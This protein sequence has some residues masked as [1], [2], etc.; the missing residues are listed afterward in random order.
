MG[1]KSLDIGNLQSVLDRAVGKCPEASIQVGNVDM[2]CLLDTGAQI[3]TIT[4]EFYRKNLENGQV[5]VDVSSFIRITAANGLNV[6]YLGYIERTLTICGIDFPNCGFLIVKDPYGTP[7]EERKVNVPGVI[8]SNILQTVQKQ[9][10][11]EWGDDHLV[12]LG[13]RPQG[14]PWQTVLALY[15]EQQATLKRSTGFVRTGKLPVIVPARV[16]KQIQGT[17][18]P[19]SPGN[20]YEAVVDRS[21]YLASH[22]PNGL[23]IGRSLVTVDQSG[24]VPVQVCNFGDQDLILAPKTRLASITA[25]FVEG[26]TVQVVDVTSDEVF[27][28]EEQSVGDEVPYVKSLLGRMDLGEVTA[29]QQHVLTDL[30]EKHLSVFSKSDDDIGCVT[31]VEHEIHTKDDIPV[32]VPHRRVP[33][34]QWAEVREYLRKTVDRGIIR[35]SSSPYASP[36][37][38]VR[39]NTGDIRLCVDYR[40][41]NAKTHKDAYPLPRIEEALESLKGA[42]HFCSLDLA[43]GYYQIPM[44]E[45]DI[46][47][48]AFRVGTG[49]LYEFTRMPFGVCNGPATFM[50]MMDKIFGDENF[51]SLLIYL[52]DILI[53]ASSFEQMIERLDMVL[54]RL[55]SNNL[56]VKPEKCH[57]MKRQIRFLGH[58]VSQEGIA[59]DPEKTR[60]VDEWEVPKS[61]SDLR[62]FLGLA[63]YYR[64][65]VPHFSQIARPLHEL[66]ADAKPKGS[67][68]VSKPK[69]KEEFAKRWTKECEEAFSNLK[70]RL[71]SA[72]VLG[73]PD[74]TRPFKLET[75]ASLRGL[76]AVLSQ[77]QDGRTVV[78]CYASR[79]LHGS[80]LNMNNYS[81]MKLELLAL[82]WAITKKF[83]DLL[84]GGKFEVYTDNNPLSYIQSTVKVGATEMRW[85]AELAVFDFTVKYRS[86]RSNRNADALSR[87]EQH[88]VEPTT[89]FEEVYTSTDLAREVRVGGE[90]MGG[91]T[92]VPCAGTRVPEELKRAILDNTSD[93]WLN[94]IQTRSTRTYTIPCTAMPSLHSTDLKQMQKQDP[95]I[96]RLWYYWE[97]GS[98]P[99]MTQVL[100]EQKPVRKLLRKWNQ[101][102][103]KEG[104]LYRSVQFEGSCVKQLLLPEVMVQSFLKAVH[105]DTA[106]P[107]A[108]K[109]LALASKRCYW[110]S[111]TLDID[112]YCRQCQRCTL[113]KAGRKL[114]STMGNLIAKKPMEILAVDFTILE[115]ACGKENVLVLTDV[116][117]KFTQAVA[118]RDQLAKTVAQCLVKEWFVRYGVPVRIH[119]DRGRNFESALIAELCQVYGIRKSRTT[120]YHPAGNGQCERFNR[121]LH[122]RL[123]TLPNEKKN[124]WPQYLPEIVY[125]YNSTPHS[126]TGYTPHFLFFGREPVLP[127]DRFLGLDDGTTGTDNVDQ[128][129]ADHYRRIEDAF[130]KAS[131]RTQ[132]E[133][134]RRNRLN[135]A[136]AE[137]TSLPIGARV[138]LKDH[139]H[140]GRHKIQDVWSSVPH[141]VIDRPFPNGNVYVVKPVYDQGESKTVNR[142]ELRDASHLPLPEVDDEPDGA[143]LLGQSDNRLVGDDREDYLLYVPRPESRLD[144]VLGP[145]GNKLSSEVEDSD[146]TVRVYHGL[147]DEVSSEPTLG[148]GASSSGELSGTS[149]AQAGEQVGTEQNRVEEQL[150]TEHSQAREQLDSLSP[151]ASEVKVVLQDVSEQPQCSDCYEGLRRTTRV[152]AGLHRNPFK[153]P[154]S[155]G[156]NELYGTDPQVLLANLAQSQLYLTQLLASQHT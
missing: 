153:L 15:G 56:K 45:R 40:Q 109:T 110:P 24:S 122:D 10:R 140:R 142:A 136:N 91:S 141:V 123:R 14:S 20:T 156:Q 90:E 66:T 100:K 138:F 58:V 104:V 2:R 71:V 11:N 132:K 145:E 148:N 38:I 80:E 8:G 3:S 116:F 42:T 107:S 97:K 65:Y 50:R 60:A 44:V 48:T 131:E 39:K 67:K 89:R 139:S 147:E 5:P 101:V 124:K 126:S 143:L 37:V 68:K 144:E 95:H 86:G 26:T 23:A 118:C 150:R 13:N 76:G 133:A 128:W 18:R 77:E 25:A 117:S 112:R 62:S 105:D 92:V 115:P 93:V 30:L 7:L 135:N 98:R 57:L 1:V 22:L 125:A 33:S 47:K 35:P 54:G 73:Y 154:Q 111:M 129:V 36:V 113:A 70:Q 74:L 83:R 108:G 46:P 61:E 127:I 59:T 81:S 17:V 9:L 134:A 137:D 94:E 31:G 88:G 75:D 69:S 149:P 102:V 114:H 41:L 121:T 34:H 29:K 120:A 63:G 119:S 49:G 84:I 152:N 53:P 151:E 19:A 103:E 6:P 85:I 130:A 27:V 72:P 155:L 55:G 106:H 146:E 4:E 32:R 52:D 21:E 64:R 99:N 78:L 16:I 82:H 96:G 87:K 43:H 28:R 12:E 51:L 79:S